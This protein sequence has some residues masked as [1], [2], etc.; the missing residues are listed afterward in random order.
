MWAEHTH[1]PA[2]YVHETR[3]SSRGQTSAVLPRPRRRW[4]LAGTAVGVRHA[5]A[6][7]GA[8]HMDEAAA[9]AAADV[10]ADVVADVG[11]EL[12]MSR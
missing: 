3:S 8:L 1:G 6:P 4:R 12:A 9:A 5:V 2:L 10:A 7:P 11:D